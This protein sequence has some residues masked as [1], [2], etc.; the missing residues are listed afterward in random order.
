MITAADRDRIFA[1]MLIPLVIYAVFALVFPAALARGFR[2]PRHRRAPIR[3]AILR[4]ASVLI[5]ISAAI[6]WWRVWGP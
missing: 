4:V 3:E 5:L 6:M 2:R 1:F